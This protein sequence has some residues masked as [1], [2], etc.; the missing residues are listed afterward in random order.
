ML[1][2]AR[3]PFIA[4]RKPAA[5]CGSLEN[6]LADYHP[7]LNLPPPRCGLIPQLLYIFIVCYCNI[8][9]IPRV[10]KLLTRPKYRERKHCLHENKQAKHQKRSKTMV[11]V[12]GGYT[13]PIIGYSPRPQMNSFCTRVRNFAPP[14]GVLVHRSTCLAPSVGVS[15][16]F[17][18]T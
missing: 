10:A 14:N 1:Q 16:S 8:L 18:P 13:R 4:P 11:R 2:H 6:R 3:A 7:A 12:E 5:A 15:R 9:Q 17:C